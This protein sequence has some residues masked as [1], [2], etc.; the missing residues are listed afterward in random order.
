MVLLGRASHMSDAI[1]EAAEALLSADWVLVAAGAGFSADSGLPT[2]EACLQSGLDY[3]SLCRAELLYEDPPRAYGWWT[4]SL[5]RYRATPSHEGYACLERLL[6]DR[7]A[8]GRV[9]VYTSN[10]DGHFRR[11]SPAIPTFEI[12]GC[13]EEWMCSSRLA[14]GAAELSFDA[15][16]GTSPADVPLQGDRFERVRSLQRELLEAVGSSGTC[17]SPVVVSAPGGWQ[18]GACEDARLVPVSHAEGTE[19]QARGRQADWSS[20]PPRCH[21]GL[22]LRPC[23][24]MFAD[25]DAALL[26]RLNAQ[27]EVY[28]HWE[29][30]ME[31]ELAAS[32]GR[33]AILELGC[34]T[35]VQSVR[36]ECECVFR[37]ASE[38]GARASLIRVNPSEDAALDGFLD[39]AEGAPGIIRVKMGAQEALRVIEEVVKRGRE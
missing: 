37:D 29:E 20:L 19:S 7:A 34:G 5:V 32:G 17:E 24:L 9:H 26:R 25:E 16:P 23:V 35:R 30:G 33:L 39:G 22:P 8:V 27:Q 14:H 2:Y 3:Q 38:R 10:V 1:A 28:Q 13:L 15:E 4:E 6:R 21:C 36:Q 31:A 11:I 12:H 18:P